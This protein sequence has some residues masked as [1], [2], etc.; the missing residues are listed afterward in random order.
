VNAV[1]SMRV[2]REVE[3]EGL[4]LPEFGMLAYPEDPVQV[5]STGTSL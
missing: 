5:L 4:D 3:L 2:S 1:K